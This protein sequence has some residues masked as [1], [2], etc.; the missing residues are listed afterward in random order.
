MNEVFFYCGHGVGTHWSSETPSTNHRTAKIRLLF[1]TRIKT[2]I[3]KPVPIKTQRLDYVKRSRCMAGV[4]LLGFML[5]LIND[6]FVTIN[7]TITIFVVFL[8]FML[9]W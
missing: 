4:W 7:P 3:M 8:I 5:D 1:D 6:T 2:P 9:L